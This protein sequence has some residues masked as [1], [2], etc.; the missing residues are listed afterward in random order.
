MGR[1][2]ANA[3]ACDVLSFRTIDAFFAH[4]SGGGR[5]TRPQRQTDSGSAG[6]GS[7]LKR[8]TAPRKETTAHRGTRDSKP[9]PEGQAGKAIDAF[10]TSSWMVVATTTADAV[11]H[12]RTSEPFCLEGRCRVHPGQSRVPTVFSSSEHLWLDQRKERKMVRRNAHRKVESCWETVVVAWSSVLLL[13]V[14]LY[15]GSTLPSQHRCFPS[16]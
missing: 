12:T 9:G 4:V 16:V 10:L 2:K 3:T 8:L 6:R 1:D 11:G 14:K 13:C 7:V 5:Q 15:K